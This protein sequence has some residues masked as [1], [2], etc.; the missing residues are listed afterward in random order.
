MAET[1]TICSSPFRMRRALLRTCSAWPACARARSSDGD[2]ARSTRCCDFVWQASQSF[3]KV[4]RC[5]EYSA[6]ARGVA[7]NLAGLDVTTLS[8]EPGSDISSSG[9]EHE[10][11]AMVLSGEPLDAIH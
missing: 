6:R 5:F 1:T 4:R 8:I 10:E 9:V 2:N 7:R 3:V 11:R